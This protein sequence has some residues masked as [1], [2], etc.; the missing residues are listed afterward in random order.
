MKPSSDVAFSA[1]VK[2]VQ[3]ERGSRGA[4]ARME[5][6][7]GF[8]TEIDDELRAFLGQIDTAF[9]ATVNA[10]GQPY[11]QHRGGPKG[12]LRALDD[13]T[14]AFPDFAGNRQYITT[15]NLRENDR[16]CLFLIDYERRRRVK[17]W[18]RARA[19]AATP[20]LI[21]RVADPTYRARIEQVLL[22]SVDAWDVNCPQHIPQKLD[23]SEVAG[24]VESLQKRILELE[25]ENA[26]LRSGVAAGEPGGPE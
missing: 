2:R 19:V 8:A 17:V 9:L 3:Q 11:L 7:G 4:Y 15:G 24:V 26:R 18:G 20:E 21:A 10:E 16:V 14:L 25:A 5:G 22:V 6:A 12:F 23:A 13:K 1:S